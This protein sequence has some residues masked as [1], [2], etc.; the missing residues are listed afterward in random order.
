MVR[1]PGD[2]VTADGFVLLIGV[3]VRDPSAAVVQAQ[4]KTN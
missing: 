1:K 4:G 3:Q 2:V